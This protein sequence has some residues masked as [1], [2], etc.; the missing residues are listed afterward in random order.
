MG[1]AGGAV[2]VLDYTF[3]NGGNFKGATGYSMRPVYQDYIDQ[4]NDPETVAEYYSDVWRQQV[5]DGA[6]E[7]GLADF[8]EQV[9]RECGFEGRLYPLD[10]PSYRAEFEQVLETCDPETRRAIEEL[11][12]DCVA[13]ECGSCGRCFGGVAFEQVFDA[14][15]LEEIERAEGKR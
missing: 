5:A 11:G 10:D 15:L 4:M 8:C 1:I 2:Y 7:L 13:W 9:V 14:G 3:D 12:G 6:T